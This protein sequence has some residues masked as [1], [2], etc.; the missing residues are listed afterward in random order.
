MYKHLVNCNL[1]QYNMGRNCNRLANP[2]D[3][4]RNLRASRISAK[5]KYD[6]L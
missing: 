2:C 6:I 5:P 3:Y 1:N 4:V